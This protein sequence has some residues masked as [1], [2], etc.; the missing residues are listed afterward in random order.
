MIR[1]LIPLFLVAGLTAC[2]SSGPSTASSD[3]ST[4]GAGG[5]VSSAGTAMSGANAGDC[6]SQAVQH[7]VG[8]PYRESLDGELKSGAG[9]TQLRVLKPGQVMTLEYNPARLNVIIESDG[10]ISALRC[11]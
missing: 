7:L 9:A 5:S 2:A 11:G 1:T 8:K 10:S 4:S 6:D 3:R